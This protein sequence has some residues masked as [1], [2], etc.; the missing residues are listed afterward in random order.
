M[1]LF[2][3]GTLKRG[4]SAAHEMKDATFLGEATTEP[5]YRLL[6]CQ[7][8]AYPGLVEAEQGGKAIA[9]E[10]YQVSHHLLQ[11]LDRYE[12]LPEGYYR[13]GQIALRP[14]APPGVE[15]YL[16]LRDDGTL[17]EAGLCW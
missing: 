12:G 5:K 3:Y 13:R 8:G 7:Q 15:G 1:I 2:V 11:H 4:H 10:L 6:V 14:P 9:G 16:Y 17:P